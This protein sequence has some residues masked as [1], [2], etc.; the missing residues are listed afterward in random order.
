MTQTLPSDFIPTQFK[1]A[2]E[3]QA[4][5]RY[6]PKL[7]C[8]KDQLDKIIGKYSF[9]EAEKLE[10]G[11]NGCNQIHWHGWVIRTK[12][13]RLTN[14]GRDCGEREFGVLFAEVE[15]VYRAAEERQS[16]LERLKQLGQERESLLQEATSL[17]DSVSRAGNWI[18]VILDELRKERFLDN[19]FRDCV[20]NGGRIQAE[21]E[22]SKRVRSAMGA[23]SGKADLKTIGV[24]KGSQAVFS[25]PTVSQELR[26]RVI[27]PLREL[28]MEN[29]LAL[30]DKELNS[31]SQSLSQI[32]Q[33]LSSA[34]NF[35]ATY[36]QFRLAE[37][38]A[39]LALLPQIIP[40]KARN[41]RVSRIVERI[42]RL[43]ETGQ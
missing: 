33:A 10:C 21:D 23:A 36:E 2:A 11:L 32:K 37:N 6:E 7:I 5:Q 30:S 38:G 35:L 24:I 15:A 4:L 18:Q 17:Y 1:T 20:R 19:A 16:R 25:G 42:E 34:R 13:G 9:T 12:D 22:D 31:K 41:S 28:T 27:D 14:C 3:F 29:M 39:A 40:K 8:E 43:Y 26:Y